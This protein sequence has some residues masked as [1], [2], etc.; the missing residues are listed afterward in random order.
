M[1]PDYAHRP[2]AIDGADGGE[3][4]H[5]GPHQAHDAIAEQR[6]MAF[7]SWSDLTRDRD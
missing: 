1:P 3:I 4:V 7:L 2:A 5:A 6:C